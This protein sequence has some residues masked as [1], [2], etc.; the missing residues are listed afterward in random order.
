MMMEMSLEDVLRE[1]D[2]FDATDELAF[3][4][5]HKAVRSAAY[6]IRSYIKSNHEIEQAC[7][8]ALGYPW[9]KDDQKNFPGATEE[10]GV[11]VNGYV[12][13]IVA[14]LVDTYTSTMLLLEDDNG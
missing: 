4:A 7:G 1:L 9:Y 2:S 5:V 10:D 6:L 11:C 12:A 3:A 14:E 13:E 8:K